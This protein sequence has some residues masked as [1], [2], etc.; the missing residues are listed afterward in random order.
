MIER[1]TRRALIL[2]IVSIEDLE[3][4]ITQRLGQQESSA[5]ANAREAAQRLVGCRGGSR[6]PPLGV[7]SEYEKPEAEGPL[8]DRCGQLDPGDQMGGEPWCQ[9]ICEA[10]DKVCQAVDRQQ[11]ADGTGHEPRLEHQVRETEDVKAEEGG[12]HVVAAIRQ[13]AWQGCQRLELCWW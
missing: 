5:L 7:D 6:R 13:S 1:V 9:E 3:D 8:S 10:V 12:V 4:E 2:S 11:N